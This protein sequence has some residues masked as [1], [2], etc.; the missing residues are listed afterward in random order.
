MIILV[1][2]M[3]DLEVGNIVNFEFHFRIQKTR[4]YNSYECFQ[5]E[6]GVSYP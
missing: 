4:V 1:Y 2:H 3:H 5:L 6:L